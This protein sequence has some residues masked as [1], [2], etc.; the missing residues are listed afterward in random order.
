MPLLLT[1][2]LIDP[3]PAGLPAVWYFSGIAEARAAR[4]VAERFGLSYV[5]ASHEGPPS[6]DAMPSTAARLE[7]HLVSAGLRE[8]GSR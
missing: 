1:L 4:A 7:A 5:R 8:G 2:T 3:L 6:G